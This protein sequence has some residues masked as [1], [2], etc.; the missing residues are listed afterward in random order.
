MV[1]RDPALLLVVV[2]AVLYPGVGAQPYS[3]WALVWDLLLATA[4]ALAAPGLPVPC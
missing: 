3:L 2:L 4:V 1:Q